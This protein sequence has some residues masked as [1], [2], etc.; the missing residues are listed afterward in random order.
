[1]GFVMFCILRSAFYV[2]VIFIIHVSVHVHVQVH[3]SVVVVVIVIVV[4]VLVLGLH[5][6]KIALH[7][8]R[9]TYFNFA[10]FVN[11]YN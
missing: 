5:S 9:G 3:V 1:M 4:N 6:I 10:Y 11:E 8:K 7:S 2:L